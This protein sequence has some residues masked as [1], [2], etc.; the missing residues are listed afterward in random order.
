MRTVVVGHQLSIDGESIPIKRNKFDRPLSDLRT[1]VEDAMTPCFFCNLPVRRGSKTS[2]RL[3]LYDSPFDDEPRIEYVHYNLYDYERSCEYALHDSSYT[4]FNY[5]ECDHCNRDICVRSPRNGWHGHFRYDDE[6]DENICLKCYEADI[7]EN[8]VSRSKIE[9]GVLPGMFF[10][11]GNPELEEA[12]YTDMGHYF[13][14]GQY[15][16]DEV[17]RII[18]DL[19]D[20]G[21]KVVIGYERLAIGGSEGTISV[22]AK[23]KE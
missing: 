1:I 21:K 17:R 14:G 4:D 3:E 9:S 11:Y 6:T 5:Q 23:D 18:L 13:I 19:M 10:S 7:L 22:H 16:S 20:Q 15:S 2:V 8:G 12:G